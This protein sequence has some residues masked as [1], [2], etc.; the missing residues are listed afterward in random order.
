MIPRLTSHIIEKQAKRLNQQSS[1]GLFTKIHQ[2]KNAYS[3]KK[4]S[5]VTVAVASL[6]SNSQTEQDKEKEKEKAENIFRNYVSFNKKSDNFLEAAIILGRYDAYANDETQFF[7][8][9]ILHQNI[10]D[11]MN[12]NLN[13]VLELRKDTS[14]TTSIQT[15]KNFTYQPFLGLLL[16]KIFGST[17]KDNR[18]KLTS[19]IIY[20]VDIPQ[21]FKFIKVPNNTY[22]D[23][24]Q[25]GGVFNYNENEYIIPKGM[26]IKITKSQASEKETENAPHYIIHILENETDNQE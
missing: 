12:N 15:A 18:K 8:G 21:N 16:E 19:Y 26:L 7:R 22:T 6:T 5:L 2:K 1:R 17:P 23:F 10:I 9:E 24:N 25:D 20:S 13:K 14:I 11:E 4:L 3:L